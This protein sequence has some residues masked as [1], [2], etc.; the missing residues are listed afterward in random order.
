LPLLVHERALG[1]L[2]LGSTQSRAFSKAVRPTLEILASHVAVSLANARML[3]RLEE[4]ATTDGLTG[5]LNK[6]ALGEAAV[7]KLRSAHRFKKPLSV[8]ICDIDH[9][10]QVNDT[11]GHDVG[12]VVIR[13]FG[14]VL[15]RI[16]RDTD[17]V[18]RFGGE[19]FVFVCEETNSAGAEHLAERVR[20]ELAATVFQ[21]E[22]GALKVT[23]SVGV[24]T[25]P[26]AGARWET[27]FK[28]AD[29]A[30]YASKR[31]GRN[32]VTVYNAKLH[33]CAA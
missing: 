3:K 7:Q 20:A 10:K 13:G 6:R 15:R 24:A 18:G 16:K 30:L 26:A 17:L 2:V 8:L 4:L 19:E 9:F 1:T 22:L 27:L 28:A 29:D 11:Y 25:Y 33:G 31:N 5:L 23:C 14:D 12:D 21:T 32:R